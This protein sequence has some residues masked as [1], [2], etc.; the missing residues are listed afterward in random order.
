MEIV[1][2]GS[3]EQVNSLIECERVPDGLLTSLPDGFSPLFLL[4]ISYVITPIMDRI[5]PRGDRGILQQ[6][7]YT[8]ED[9]DRIGQRIIKFINSDE[10]WE[11]NSMMQDIL[12][13]G[14]GH[15]NPAQIKELLDAFE[16]GIS[17]DVKQ[18]R[19]LTNVEPDTRSSAESL[20]SDA[21]A[22]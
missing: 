14:R 4:Y 19:H 7:G 20:G 8:K 21:S 2:T 13:M 12:T 6:S 10:T 22:G 16:L 15:Y 17:A 3:K 1:E 5:I 9:H 18:K 11:S